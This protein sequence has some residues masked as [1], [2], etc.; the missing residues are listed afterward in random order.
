MAKKTKK[1]AE[2]IT[3]APV[4]VEKS[5]VFSVKF[6]G[7]NVIQSDLTYRDAIKKVEQ[8]EDQDRALKGKNFTEGFYEIV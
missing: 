2:E 5:G 8:L 3:V 4:E 1:V 7:G 6:T